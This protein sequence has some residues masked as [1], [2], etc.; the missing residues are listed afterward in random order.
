MQDYR[1]TWEIDI[2]A[3]SPKEAIKLAVADYLRP[4]EPHRWSYTAQPMAGGPVC[5][6]DYATGE[7]TAA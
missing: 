6:M 3:D 1:V 2:P 7:T 5:T 4:A